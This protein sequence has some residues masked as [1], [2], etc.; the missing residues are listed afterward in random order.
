MKIIKPKKSNKNKKEAFIDSKSLKLKK[1]RVSEFSVWKGCGN[2][3]CSS[4]DHITCAKEDYYIFNK[5]EN[6]VFV[7]PIKKYTL[8]QAKKLNK[9]YNKIVYANNLNI[10]Q[11]DSYLKTKKSTFSFFDVQKTNFFSYNNLIYKKQEQPK[12]LHEQN[13]NDYDIIS[14]KNSIKHLRHYDTKNQN[15]K[16]INKIFDYHNK[17]KNLD[18]TLIQSPLLQNKV[19]K[20]NIKEKFIV[21]L[22]NEKVQKKRSKIKN[23]KKILKKFL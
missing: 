6:G 14:I 2:L 7:V 21:Q 18:G 10:N 1:D 20:K 23:I 13:L 3:N 15:Y 11:D 8:N 4:R 19:N 22:S 12:N 9:N 17:Q 5:Q 16:R